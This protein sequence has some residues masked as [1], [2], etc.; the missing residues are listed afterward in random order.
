MS[1]HGGAPYSNVLKIKNYIILNKKNIK[2][3]PQRV[4]NTIKYTP[5][6]IRRIIVIISF[7]RF[8]ST[9]QTTY[10]FFFQSQHCHP[11]IFHIYG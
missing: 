4:F 6:N 3:I 10:F 8:G 1:F 2:Y 9:N 7:N 11:V 5:T